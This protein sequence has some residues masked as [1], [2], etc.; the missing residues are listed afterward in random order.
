MALCFCVIQSHNWLGGQIWSYFSLLSC[1]GGPPIAE[2][3]NMFFVSSSH[4]SCKYRQG[5]TKSEEDLGSGAR[6]LQ[7]CV[8]LPRALTPL[9]ILGINISNLLFGLNSGQKRSSA[10]R[11]LSRW[12]QT[13]QFLS[14]KLTLL[15]FLWNNASVMLWSLEKERKQHL[16]FSWTKKQ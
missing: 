11:N 5:G 9:C 12:W 1:A 14:P 16:Y 8:A 10:L 2:I 6:S 15:V 13:V 4:K 3:F 7:A